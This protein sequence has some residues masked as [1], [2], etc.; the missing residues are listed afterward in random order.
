MIHRTQSGGGKMKNEL[1]I[2]LYKAIKQHSGLE[3]ESMID[4]GNYGASGGFGGF[5]Y[6][7]DTCEFYDNNRGIIWELLEQD[8]EEYGFDNVIAFV[9]SFNGAN[10]VHDEAT[11]KNLCA[12]YVLE[13][14]GR[15]IAGLKECA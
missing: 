2:N 14:I 3:Y 13:T 7:T 12:W 1:Y 11:F 6:Y 9:G 8:A 10:D 4:A 15:W 5:V